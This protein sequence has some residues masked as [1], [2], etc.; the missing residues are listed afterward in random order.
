NSAIV[1]MSK[2]YD[3]IIMGAPSERGLRTILFGSTVFRVADRV[4]CAVLSLKVPRHEVHV[5]LPVASDE[6]FAPYVQKGR[7]RAALKVD[8]KRDL[9]ATISKTMAQGTVSAGQIER[10]MLLRELRQNTALRNGVSISAPA[11]TGLRD[12]TLGVFVLREPIDFQ[13]PERIKVDLC[14]VVLASPGARQEQLQI[15]ARVTEMV[16][17]PALLQRLRASEGVDEL[18]RALT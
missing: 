10:A 16:R 5:G 7:H 1:D 15:I 9:I 3:L 11:I 12:T 13:S 8:N 4:N 18:T 6:Q 14:I 2:N 17:N